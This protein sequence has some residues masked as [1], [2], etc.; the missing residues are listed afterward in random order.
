MAGED[1]K[2]D[3]DLDELHKLLFGVRR[4]ARYHVRR[5]QYFERLDKFIKIFTTIGALG[6]VTTILAKANEW[7][8]L[9]YG[10]AAGFFSLL[11]IVIGT[12]QLA[13]T[14]SDLSAEFIL[15]EKDMVLAGDRIPK[16]ELAKFTARR[17]EIEIK[18]PPPLRVLDR[19]CYNDL[20]RA[21]G[22]DKSCQKKVTRLQKFF[23]PFFDYRFG[24]VDGT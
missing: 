12:S 8:T 19:L 2:C 11:D 6:T 7:W 13:R 4:S 21:M 5:Q 9:G 1:Q 14:H 23:S 10:T 20:V 15:L 24:D 3:T 22:Y 17:L 16:S 18:E